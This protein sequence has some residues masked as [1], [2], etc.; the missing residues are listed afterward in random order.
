MTEPLNDHPHIPPQRPR[1]GAEPYDHGLSGTGG[2][3][4]SHEATPGPENRSQGRAVCGAQYIRPG[5]GLPGDR[6]IE[7]GL[8]PGHGADHAEILERGVPSPIGMTWPVNERGVPAGPIMF[9]GPDGPAPM[10][11][12]GLVGPH[13]AHSYPDGGVWRWCTGI[14]SDGNPRVGLPDC[15]RE[16]PRVDCA[17][18]QGTGCRPLDADEQ[19]VDPDCRGGKHGSCGGGPCGC[20]CHAASEQE[21]A[22]RR[23][24]LL[25]ELTADAVD[26]GEYGP[27]AG[28][29]PPADVLDTWRATGIVQG[30]IPVA[31]PMS[32]FA[33]RRM[34]ECQWVGPH[35]AHVWWARFEDGERFEVYCHGK[36][37]APGRS[38]DEAR[39]AIR[40]DEVRGAIDGAL[41]KLKADVSPDRRRF[42]AD[43]V[44]DRVAGPLI[45]ER[46]EAR[47]KAEHLT[48]AIGVMGGELDGANQAITELHQRA[49]RAEAQA[50]DRQ[51]EITRENGR[52]VAERQRAEQE[53]ARADDE[54]RA[55]RQRADRVDATLAK[56]AAERDE[57][58]AERDWYRDQ[59]AT[60]EY[61]NRHGRAVLDRLRKLTYA[62]DDGTEYE[63]THPRGEGERECPACWAAD[64]RAALGSTDGETP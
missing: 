17:A 40:A 8:P 15:Y 53:E 33:R 11:R 64:I 62:S 28:E 39:G 46:N 44:M 6:I 3:P 52:Y 26:H 1:A 14:T 32:P 50:R 25:G 12:G 9:V 23:G 2:T 24:Q 18:C 29:V 48:E 34:P 13:D 43:L 56:V 45:A 36:D 31:D 38:V 35:A 16:T 20:T 27:P 19:L 22:G 21:V 60:A 4:G 10:C 55:A 41:G 61:A 7:C 59:L 63:H 57:A 47:F 54:V 49:E 30:R 5:G 51:A 42:V 37:S 58:I